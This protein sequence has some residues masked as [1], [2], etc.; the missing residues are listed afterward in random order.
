MPRQ[1]LGTECRLDNHEKDCLYNREGQL[2]HRCLRL[3]VLITQIPP[4]FLSHN[5]N[6]TDDNDQPLPAVN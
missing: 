2:K 5:A 3:Q 6:F 4:Y 1:T